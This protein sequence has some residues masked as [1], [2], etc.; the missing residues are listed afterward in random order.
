MAEHMGKS[1]RNA[2]AASFGH[3]TSTVPDMNIRQLTGLQLVKLN[4]SFVGGIFG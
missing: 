3:R 1:C 2:L 4:V